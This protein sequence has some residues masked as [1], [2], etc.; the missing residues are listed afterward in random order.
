M[1]PSV[2]YLRC[3]NSAELTTAGEY[4]NIVVNCV[5]H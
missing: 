4:R 5:V 1:V 3:G 2:K